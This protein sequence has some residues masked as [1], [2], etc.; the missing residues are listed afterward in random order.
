MNGWFNQMIELY[1]VN[2]SEDISIEKFNKFLENIS[3]E[4]QEKIKNSKNH[5]NALRTLIGDILIRYLIYKHL[6][7]NKEDIIFD[8]NEFGKPYLKYCKNFYFNISHSGDWVVCAIADS[9]VGIDIELIKDIK[10]DIAKRFFSSEEYGELMLKPETKR[11]DYFYEL[12]VLKESY[13]KAIG[14]GLSIPLNSFSIQPYNN[15]VQMLSKN[16]PTNYIFKLHNLSSDYKLAVC[17]K[18][19]N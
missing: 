7:F 13:I 19:K 1:A 3:K 17:I 8:K 16:N 14:A 2:I 10:L 6:K 15:K 11:V 18:T 4:K 9:E 12:W 5:K